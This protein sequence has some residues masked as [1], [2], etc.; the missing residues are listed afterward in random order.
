MQ[1]RAGA[2]RRGAHLW[3]FAVAAERQLGALLVAL[4][5]IHHQELARARERERGD[6]YHLVVFIY[7]SSSSNRGKTQVENAEAFES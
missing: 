6:Y 1:Y 2:A 5:A 7:R 4:S 3:H